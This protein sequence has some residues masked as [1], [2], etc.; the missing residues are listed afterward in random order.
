MPARDRRDH[1]RKCASFLRSPRERLGVFVRCVRSHAAVR[2]RGAVHSVGAALCDGIEP[3]ESLEALSPRVDASGSSQDELRRRVD[4]VRDC[5]PRTHAPSGITQHRPRTLRVD[6]RD[7]EN[8]HTASFQTVV[9][10]RPHAEL[11]HLLPLP[12]RWSAASPLPFEW[13]SEQRSRD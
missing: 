13:P 12:A 7:L 11:A 6:A 3:N 10:R 2:T 4:I 9:G 1:A 5:R 8:A